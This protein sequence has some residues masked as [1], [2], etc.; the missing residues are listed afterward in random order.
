MFKQL[1]GMD[2]GTVG[3]P[4]YYTNDLKGYLLFLHTSHLKDYNNECIIIL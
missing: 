2:T 4:Q 3:G 1:S